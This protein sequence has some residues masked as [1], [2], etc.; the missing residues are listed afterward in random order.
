MKFD[1]TGTLDFFLQDSNTSKT[2][3]RKSES[4]RTSHLRVTCVTR[5]HTTF[6]LQASS[7]HLVHKSRPTIWGG[8]Q[9]LI[10]HPRFGVMLLAPPII[11][12]W[13]GIIDI[14]PHNMGG[15]I[16]TYALIKNHNMRV[17]EQ[18]YLCSITISSGCKAPG[19]TNTWNT[20][21]REL[22]RL[23]KLFPPE[24]TLVFLSPVG[25]NSSIYAP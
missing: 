9:K 23:T 11:F 17:R 12:S 20:P 5:H 15:G 3:Q 7:D 21:R 4:K 10:S 25:E 22:V 24:K 16:N 19:H 6:E 8:G 14:P 1:L 2:P 18:L 13:G